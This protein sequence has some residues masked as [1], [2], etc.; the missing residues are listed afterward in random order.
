M[1]INKL[2]YLLFQRL[3]INKTT[4]KDKGIDKIKDREDL[5]RKFEKCIKKAHELVPDS[6]KNRTKISLGATGGIRL[7]GY[8]IIKFYFHPQSKYH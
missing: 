4:N 8:Y 2:D 6:R 5:R 1:V 3:V 7:L